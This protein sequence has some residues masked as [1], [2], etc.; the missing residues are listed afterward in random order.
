MSIQEV[1]PE[2]LARSF[3]HYYQAL[4]QDIG[5]AEHPSRDAWERISPRERNCIIEATRLALL[6]A[7]AE[8]PSNKEKVAGEFDSRRYFAKPGEAEWGC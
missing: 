1:S 7:A 4:A 5:C 3:H 6:E 2:R 8:A